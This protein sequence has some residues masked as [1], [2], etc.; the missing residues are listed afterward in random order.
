MFDIDEDYSDGLLKYPKL[1]RAY[2]G[3]VERYGKP[4][5]A[6]YSKKDTLDLLQKNLR[7]SASQALDAYEFDLLRLDHG[8][9]TPVFLDD[10]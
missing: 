6:C 8:E 5:I 2:I 9:A 1:E 3:P 10:V 4:P 7:L